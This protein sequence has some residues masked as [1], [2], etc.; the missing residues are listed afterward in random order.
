MDVLHDLIAQLSQMGIPF[1]LGDRSV[2]TPADIAIIKHEI[3]D[4]IFKQKE[5]IYARVQAGR[6]EEISTYI[7]L[8]AS[9]RDHRPS[10]S[11]HKW[12]RRIKGP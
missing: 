2:D 7:D 5:E 12:L 9:R 8:I 1:V 4:I 3:E 10:L 6:W 11:G